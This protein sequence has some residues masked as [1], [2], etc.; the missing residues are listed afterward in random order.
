LRPSFAP[1]KRNDSLFDIVRSRV[2]QVVNKNHDA[3]EAASEV[4]R[5]K[6]VRMATTSDVWQLL[7]T[8]SLRI[9]N[10]IFVVDGFDECIKVD[11]ALQIHAPVVGAE[12]LH[13]RLRRIFFYEYEITRPDTR[14]DINSTVRRPALTLLNRKFISFSAEVFKLSRY[15]IG[16]TVSGLQYRELRYRQHHHRDVHLAQNASSR[17]VG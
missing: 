14:D 2:T 12:F 7:K 11:K 17:R 16:I 4:Y 10:C 8:I 5:G 13:Q 3:L 6:E 9:A 15:G 1:Q